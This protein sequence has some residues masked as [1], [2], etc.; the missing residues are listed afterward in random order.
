MFLKSMLSLALVFAVSCKQR[1]FNNESSVQKADDMDINIGPN[2]AMCE[3]KV[4]NRVTNLEL[5]GVYKNGKLTQV[6]G[7]ATTTGG[8]EG[9]SDVFRAAV[10]AVNKN[11]D[12]KNATRSVN[13]TML[14]N[15]IIVAKGEGESVV[16]GFLNNLFITSGHGKNTLR[17]GITLTD[18]KTRRAYPSA[19]PAD[20]FN[21]NM[22]DEGL[23]LFVP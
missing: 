23:N 11:V 13:I 20:V 19:N 1:G 22:T 17:Y 2:L 5:N 10:D 4:G 8:E 3:Y 7:R 21:C 15:G 14:N 16:I 6:A 12:A 18:K 9:G